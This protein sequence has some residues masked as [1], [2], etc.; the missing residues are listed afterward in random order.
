[1]TF[2]KKNPNQCLLIAHGQKKCVD[3]KFLEIVIKKK[4]FVLY[5]IKHS[6]LWHI[7]VATENDNT[8]HSSQYINTLF[9]TQWHYHKYVPYIL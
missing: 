4:H 8:T 5:Y 9:V 2:V 1:M 3:V 7:V 6:R